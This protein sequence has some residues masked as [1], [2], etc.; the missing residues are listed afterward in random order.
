LAFGHIVVLNVNCIEMT[1]SGHQSH[2]ITYGNKKR[3]E[4][5][6]TRDEWQSLVQTPIKPDSLANQQ[7]F[8]NTVIASPSPLIQRWKSNS[9]LIKG[10][11]SK[12]GEKHENPAFSMQTD[13]ESDA[14]WSE[15]IKNLEK[16][17]YH[18]IFASA[19]ALIVK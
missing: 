7:A 1:I 15:I 13:D 4:P 3:T 6:L 11:M 14:L 10:P 12:A 2:T 18:R 9:S 5:K 8:R 16:D 19:N 17:R